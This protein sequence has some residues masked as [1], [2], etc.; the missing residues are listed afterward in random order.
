MGLLIGSGLLGL[1]PYAYL[2]IA[3]RAASAAW[4]SWGDQSTLRG[5]LTH[6]LRVEYVVSPHARPSLYVVPLPSTRLSLYVE[7]VVSPLPL[8]PARYVHTSHLRAGTRLTHR[9]WPAPRQVRHLPS[10]QHPRDDG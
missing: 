1:T 7:Y 3:G 2:P 5:L 10:C 9:I 8:S 4:G 6:V